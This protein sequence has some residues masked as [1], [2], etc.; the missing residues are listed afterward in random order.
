MR[1]SLLPSGFTDS[2]QTFK[3]FVISSTSGLSQAATTQSTSS[4]VYRNDVF[5]LNPF[6]CD[7][8]PDIANKVNRSLC[9]WIRLFLGRVA[10]C[11]WVSG[12][13]WRNPYSQRCSPQ[14]S[15]LRHSL[16][17]R[18]LGR[19]LPP[20]TG[21]PRSP[22]VGQQQS[23]CLLPGVLVRV[24]QNSLFELKIKFPPWFHPWVRLQNS[25]TCMPAS[26]M[27]LSLSR[28]SRRDWKRTITLWMRNPDQHSG[29]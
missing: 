16:K 4:L 23:S 22:S 12:L 26:T 8:L 15:C 29:R 19:E 18:S 11:L 24:L 6:Y 25:E 7:G 3:D 13:R 21:E 20:S 27:K 14:T 28:G 5:L 9:E 1:R 10:G 2:P 17:G